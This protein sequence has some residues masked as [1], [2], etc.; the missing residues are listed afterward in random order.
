MITC[1]ECIDFLIDYVSDELTPEQK[2]HIDH[3]LQFCPPCVTYIDTYKATIRL[4]RELPM[5][6]VPPEL[7]A[8]LKEVL[9][10]DYGRS[11]P[12]TGA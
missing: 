9:A 5:K 6:P 4:T 2:A 8:R 3:H 11:S 10:S 7:I 12:S 1:R